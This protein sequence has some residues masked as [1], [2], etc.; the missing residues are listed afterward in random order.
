VL[1]KEGRVFI[2][3]DGG[4]PNDSIWLAI[5]DKNGDGVADHFQL[6]LDMT[7]A[8]LETEEN[9]GEPTGFLFLDNKTLLFN[10]QG[11][12]RVDDFGAAP[13]SR[14]MMIELGGSTN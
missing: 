2:A 3:Q 11:G 12:D 10:W 13:R 7:D 14:I 9:E 8:N 4:I 1:D 6:F 5:P